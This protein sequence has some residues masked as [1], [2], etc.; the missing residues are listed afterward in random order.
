VRTSGQGAANEQDLSLGL[1]PRI[2]RRTAERA[3]LVAPQ[4]PFIEPVDP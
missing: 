1:V 2:R 4:T 3:P